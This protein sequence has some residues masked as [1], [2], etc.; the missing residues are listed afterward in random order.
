MKTFL[1]D[2]RRKLAVGETK[3]KA[4]H[5]AVHHWIKLAHQSIE[6]RGRFAVALSGGSTP[7]AIYA[8]LTSPDYAKQLDWTKILLFWS[9][10][11]AVP[12]NHPAS[13][14]HMAMTSGLSQVPAQIFRMEAEHNIEAHAQK[15]EELIQSTLETSLFDLVMLGVGEDGH[16]ASLFPDTAALEMK[17][18]LVVPN[19]VQQKNVWRMTLTFPCINQ[20]HHAA[21][22]VLGA[23]KASIVQKV[24]MNPIYPA[25]QIGTKHRKALWILDQESSSLIPQ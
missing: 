3:E 25:S 13:N 15:Y 4:V 9:D 12:P 11:R 8:L 16:T 14:Y 17:D 18:R 22:Y 1:F 21:L 7:N 19:F 6:Q 2:E 20:S 24:L 5:F 10:E 23:S